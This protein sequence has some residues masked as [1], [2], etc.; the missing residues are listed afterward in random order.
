MN[1]NRYLLYLLLCGLMLYYAL[2]R[3]S[4][5]SLGLESLFAGAWLLFALFVIAGNLSAFL[6]TPKKQKVAK[7]GVETKPRRS[8][9]LSN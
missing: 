8:R 1:K 4:F 9:G 3:I 7:L 5:E 2:P 6:Y